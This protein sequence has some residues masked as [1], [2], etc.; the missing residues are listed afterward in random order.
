MRSGWV[1]LD[2]GYAVKGRQYH[3]PSVSRA[4]PATRTQFLFDELANL[5]R[6]SR[7][8]RDTLPDAGR[9]EPLTHL[10]TKPN[11]TSFIVALMRSPLIVP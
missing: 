8:P 10:L 4:L 11:V 5:G 1:E 6:V 3:R 2:I 9:G 7:T